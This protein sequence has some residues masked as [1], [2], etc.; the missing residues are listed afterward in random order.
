MITEYELYSDERE[1]R[2]E[3]SRYLFVGGVI[4]TDNGRVRL[5]GELE[6]IRGEHGLTGEVKWRKASKRYLDV[7]GDWV[8]VFFDDPYARYSALDECFDQDEL[9]CFHLRS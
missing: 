2:H 4:C 5:Q 6:S 3:G 7:Y 1:V 8:R 9:G